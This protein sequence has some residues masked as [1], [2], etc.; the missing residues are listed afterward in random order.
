MLSSSA[1]AGTG[2]PFGPWPKI[3]AGNSRGQPVNEAL[4]RPSAGTA[5]LWMEQEGPWGPWP[6]IVAENSCGRGANEALIIT[7]HRCHI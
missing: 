1:V 4:I 6:E 5:S 2:G 7:C 3:V